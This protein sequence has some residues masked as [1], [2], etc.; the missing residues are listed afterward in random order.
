MHTYII[1]T[2]QNLSPLNSGNS[3]LSQALPSA[4]L[5]R[6]CHPLVLAPFLLGS[7]FYLQLRDAEIATTD[8]WMVTGGG[9]GRKGKKINA[10]TRHDFLLSKN[11]FTEGTRQIS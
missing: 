11:M 9:G 1:H 7:I 4:H 2:K 5:H 6:K 10:W 8:S 3:L